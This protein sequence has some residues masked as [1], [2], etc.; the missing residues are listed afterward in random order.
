MRGSSWQLPLPARRRGVGVTLEM[1][2]PSAEQVSAEADGAAGHAYG[3]H[4][5]VVAAPYHER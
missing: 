5:D 3:G 1:L 4:R 2:V